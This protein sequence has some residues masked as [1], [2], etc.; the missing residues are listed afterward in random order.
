MKKKLQLIDWTIQVLE[1]LRDE[2]ITFLENSKI[3]DE[4]TQDQIFIAE[5]NIATIQKCIEQQKVISNHIVYFTSDDENR[6]LIE[7]GS[8]D[9]PSELFLTRDGKPIKEYKVI[10]EKD[11]E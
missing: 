11:S 1:H 8:R 7:I 5:G 3:H 9:L 10:V 4:Y 2:W 6:L